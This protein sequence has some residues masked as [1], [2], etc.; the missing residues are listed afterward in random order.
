[1]K[2]ITPLCA[3]ATL[4]AADFPGLFIW[5]EGCPKNIPT[6]NN[7]RLDTLENYTGVWYNNIYSDIAYQTNNAD[8]TVAQYSIDPSDPSGK[9]VI[10]DNSQNRERNEDGTWGERTGGLGSATFIDNGNLDVHFSDF[11]KIPSE[12]DG[13]IAG[14]GRGNYN[15]LVTDE[16][17]QS[18][19]Y[20]FACT[21]LCIFGNFCLY[22]QPQMWV[23]SRSNDMSQPWNGKT[24]EERS[25]EL[26]DYYRAM[27]AS[28]R[29][30]NKV[31]ESF[32]FSTFDT[33]PTEQDVIEAD[34]EK[35][36]FGIFDVFIDAFWAILGY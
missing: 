3:S 16:L 7:L 4:V 2:L 14:N 28:E 6:T 30:V 12:K 13:P 31:R 1:M 25:E 19:S 17:M 23:L 24:W 32:T 36:S 35:K 10:V 29:A 11:T 8:C 5:N 34:D 33:C 18:H 22:S 9:T 26:L 21:D 20:V 15:I 27:G